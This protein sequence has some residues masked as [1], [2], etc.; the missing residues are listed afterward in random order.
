MKNTVTKMIKQNGLSFFAL[1]IVCVCALPFL[2]L[3]GFT[4]SQSGKIE[5]IIGILLDIQFQKAL[6]STLVIALCVTGI[7]TS[8]GMLVALFVGLSDI[9]RM[10]I[11]SFLIMF[12]FFLPPTFLA[13]AW[14]DVGVLLDNAFHLPNPMYH[15]GATVVLLSIHLFPLAFFMILESLR[16]IPVSMIEAGRSCRLDS[17]G[18]L[19]QIIFP[20][21]RPV[22]VKSAMLIWFSC[23]GHFTFYALLGIPGQFTTLTTLIYAKLLGFGMQ[24]LPEVVFICL[25]LIVLGLCGVILLRFFM[26]KE[27]CYPMTVKTLRHNTFQSRRVRV[28]VYGFLWIISLSIVLPFIKLL[29]TSMT[30]KAFVSFSFRDMSFENYSYILH[31]KNVQ[32]AFLNSLILGASTA[33][34]L[35]F[36]SA[37]FEYGSLHSRKGVFKSARIFLQSLYLLPGSILAISMIL[38]FLKPFSWMHFLRLPLLYDTLFIVLIAYII[39]FFAFHLN[40]VHSAGEKFSKKWIESAKSSGASAFFTIK[41]IFLPIMT[42]SLLQGS[43]LVFILILHEVTVSALLPSSDTQTLGVILLTMMEH[44]DTKATAALCILITV[45]LALLRYLVHRFFIKRTPFRQI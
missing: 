12:I 7:A 16:K 19:R 15:P 10:H 3:L 9:H 5:K 29:M 2:K 4:L 36:K 1:V 33:F 27:W 41:E 40:I 45:F 21:L 17:Q 30:P 37:I 43:F 11:W 8:L 26:G 32:K 20:L 38:L 24:N 6:G 18:I 23:L 44:G 25:M 22:I 42:P 13:I 14:V 28:M 35:F 34:L 39:R 31:N